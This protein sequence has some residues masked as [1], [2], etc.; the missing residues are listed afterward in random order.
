LQENVPYVFLYW[1]LKGFF[2]FNLRP[3]Y[4]RSR[5]VPNWNDFQIISFG[6]AVFLFMSFASPSR[7]FVFSLSRFRAMKGEVFQLHKATA[8]HRDSYNDTLPLVGRAV[9]RVK[10]NDPKNDDPGHKIFFGSG[11][12]V[13]FFRA[14]QTSGAIQYFLKVC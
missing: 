13:F 11:A 7:I 6:V 4:E 5:D 12:R 10:K 3:R 8:R 1:N 9:A 14:T 2:F